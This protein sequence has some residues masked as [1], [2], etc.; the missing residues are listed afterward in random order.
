MTTRKKNEL[1][2]ARAE[3]K[4][5]EKTN[6]EKQKRAAEDQLRKDLAMTFR[7]AHGQ[8]ALLFIMKECGFGN[9][10]VGA[11]HRGDIDEKRTT[12]GALRLNLYLKLRKLLPVSILKEVEYHEH[13]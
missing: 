2:S 9:P 12:Y 3:R 5:E 6:L 10:I 13:P 11:D 7:T 8:R 4:V 1:P